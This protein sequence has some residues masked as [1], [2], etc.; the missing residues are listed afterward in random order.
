[1][2][3]FD[4][5]PGGVPALAEVFNRHQI[6]ET[7]IHVEGCRNLVLAA[8]DTSGD[9]AYVL[10]L[11]DDEAAYQR[12]IDHPERGVATEDLLQLVAGEF[13]PT[14]PAELWSVLR[15]VNV[16]SASPVAGS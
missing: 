2:L 8:P 12:W 14:A 15:A 9:T 7:A 13:E 1:M 16:A 3:R 11:W 10:G 5:K 6:L 4:L